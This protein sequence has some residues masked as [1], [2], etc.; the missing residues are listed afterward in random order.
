MGR[1]PLSLIS[2][3]LFN[4]TRFAVVGLI[5]S[6]GFRELVVLLEVIHDSGG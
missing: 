6:A 5:L 4:A 3:C 1:G 2:Q